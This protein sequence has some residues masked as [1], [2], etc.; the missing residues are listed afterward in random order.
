VSDLID[1][2]V[3]LL[4]H[5]DTGPTTDAGVGDHGEGAD[6][7]HLPVNIGNPGEFTVIELARKPEPNPA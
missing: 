4:L 2:I 3:K 7:I 5:R 6:D 1:G